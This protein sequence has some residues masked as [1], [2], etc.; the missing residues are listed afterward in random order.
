MGVE[1]YRTVGC[2]GLKVWGDV[3][4]EGGHVV[5]LLE[6]DVILDWMGL[7]N[8][9]MVE[10]EIESGGCFWF[11]EIEILGFKVLRKYLKK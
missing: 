3:A 2:G 5:L 1:V 8:G 11:L 9:K 4:E 6:M 10:E 7:E